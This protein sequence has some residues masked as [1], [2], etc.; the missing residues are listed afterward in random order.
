MKPLKLKMDSLFIWNDVN[1]CVN[2]FHKLIIQF[3]ELN[4]IIK[5]ENLKNIQLKARITAASLCSEHHKEEL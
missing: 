2:I 1:K 3:V 4:T 5:I